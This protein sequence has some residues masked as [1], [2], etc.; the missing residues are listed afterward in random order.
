[1]TR[2]VRRDFM[3]LLDCERCLGSG[4]LQKITNTVGELNSVRKLTIIQSTA[5]RE[6]NRPTFAPS[7]KFEES[8]SQ[9]LK[10]MRCEEYHIRRVPDSRLQAS[11]PL[12]DSQKD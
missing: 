9:L 12:S 6:P 1:M 2:S 5:H 10:L 7:I 8:L 3:S 11:I 4:Q